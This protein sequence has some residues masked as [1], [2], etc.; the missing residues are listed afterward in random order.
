MTIIHRTGQTGAERED[1]KQVHRT[2][3]FPDPEEMRSIVLITVDKIV[4]IQ[5]RTLREELSSTGE[6]QIQD[7]VDLSVQTAVRIGLQDPII[8]QITAAEDLQEAITDRVI[9]Q[10][11]PVVLTGLQTDPLDLLP[12]IVQGAIADPVAF[13]LQAQAEA[14]P[15]AFDLQDR[16]E[17]DPAEAAGQVVAEVNFTNYIAESLSSLHFL[18]LHR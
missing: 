12:T 15:V 7:Q 13:D 4:L 5:I 2:G 9:V 16:A 6:Q 18:N 10:E 8:G 14:D 17:A 3:L 11:A 1:L